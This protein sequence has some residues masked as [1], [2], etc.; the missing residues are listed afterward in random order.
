MLHGR[1]YPARLA[2][3]PGRGRV[4]VVR[5]ARGKIGEGL[6]H[7]GP[8]HV[9]AWT[10]AAVAGALVDF[11]GEVF[12][13]STQRH[14]RFEVVVR[15]LDVGESGALVRFE[16]LGNPYRIRKPPLGVEGRP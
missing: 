3:F 4:D 1:L 8:E 9:E 16:S 7:L 12:D 11:E 5:S 15:L 10:D 2:G 14:L 6:F 13:G